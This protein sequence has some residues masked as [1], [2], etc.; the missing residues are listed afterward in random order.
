MQHGHEVPRPTVVGATWTWGGGAMD[1]G[2]RGHGHGV[3]TAWM[4]GGDSMGMGWRW[5]R[6]EGHSIAMRSSDPRWWGHMDMGW[7]WHRQR[8]HRDMRLAQGPQTH[9][10]GAVWVWGG[11]GTGR[12]DTRDTARP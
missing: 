2:W 11:G 4:W 5:H 7:R 9:G 8:G 1:M 3:E 6:C 12:G 10:G